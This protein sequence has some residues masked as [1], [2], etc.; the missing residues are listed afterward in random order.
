M[1][2]IKIEHIAQGTTYGI[3]KAAENMEFFLSRLPAG[4]MT[5]YDALR[6]S[7]RRKREFL[8]SRMLLKHLLNDDDAILEIKQNGQLTVS[9]DSRNIS[10]SHSSN[11]AAAIVS[12]AY[13]TGID[14]EEI[15]PRVRRIMHKFLNADE[16][17]ALGSNPEL[18]KIILCWSA[19]ESIYKM[20]GHP[21]LSFSNEITLEIPQNEKEK[22]CNAFIR[23]NGKSK[24]LKIFFGQI[25]AFVFTYCF[26]NDWE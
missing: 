15:N 13:P 25:E 7:E 1:S 18:W 21:G 9:G 12:S 14:I 11:M 22:I 26:D 5:G 16:L 2:L 6:F 8:A 4:F 24:P 23:K 3:W 17:T 10:I 19:K 20:L